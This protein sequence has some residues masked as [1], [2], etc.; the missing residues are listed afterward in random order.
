[1]VPDLASTFFI[2][3]D[4]SYDH[5]NAVVADLVELAE[6]FGGDYDGWGC[7]VQKTP[8]AT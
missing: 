2:V 1:M 4:E 5:I 8:P 6:K 3:E 7:E